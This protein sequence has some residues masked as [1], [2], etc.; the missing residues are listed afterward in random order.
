MPVTL[1][2]GIDGKF[3]A[4]PLNA[5]TSSRHRLQIKRCM[6]HAERHMHLAF[7]V[8]FHDALI[9]QRRHSIMYPIHVEVESAGQPANGA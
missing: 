7:V 2:K 1:L 4:T 8:A 5:I 9:D 3:G 6:D